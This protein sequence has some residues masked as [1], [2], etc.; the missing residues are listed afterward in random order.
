MP[1][2][3]N[4]QS[5][6]PPQSQICSAVPVTR[7]IGIIFFDK[8]RITWNSATQKWIFFVRT[9]LL[10]NTLLNDRQSYSSNLSNHEKEDSTNVSVSLKKI[11]NP[12]PIHMRSPFYTATAAFNLIP[13]RAK[14]SW[15][16]YQK[17]TSLIVGS[18]DCPKEPRDRFPS[19]G[20]D[21]SRQVKTK[22]MWIFGLVLSAVLEELL[23]SVYIVLVT[24]SVQES[25]AAELTAIAELLWDFGGGGELISDL[26]YWV[27]WRD[28]LTLY[29]FT[30]P[31]APLSFAAPAWLNSTFKLKLLL[32]FR[33]AT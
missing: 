9:C 21:Q 13:A 28:L 4:I 11:K 26:I 1:P 27:G 32:C 31:R 10:K 12:V 19:P 18:K 22:L 24:S 3:P 2:P 15:C 30:R 20:Q 16:A 25:N 6:P 7:L 23:L 33:R 8:G 17:S 29:N 5:C 14:S